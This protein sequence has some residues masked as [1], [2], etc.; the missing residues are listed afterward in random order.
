MVFNVDSFEI[1]KN[2]IYEVKIDEIENIK[3]H[4]YDFWICD[5]KAHNYIKIYLTT[6]TVIG[7]YKFLYFFKNKRNSSL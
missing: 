7:P 6:H 2:K 5:K 1:L 4:N 3:A